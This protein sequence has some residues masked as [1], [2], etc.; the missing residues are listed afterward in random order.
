MQ[1]I[2]SRKI[3]EDKI[4]ENFVD[5]QDLFI[6]IQSNFLTGLHKRYQSIKSGN[7]VL[8]FAKQAH[9]DILKQKDYDFNFNFSFEKFWENHSLIMPTKKSIIKIAKDICIPKETA[10]RK[11]LQLIK[12][13]ILSKKNN[14]TG[15]LPSERYKKSYD[16]FIQEEIDGFTKLL[17][18]ICKKINIS[19]TNEEIKEEIK[20]KFNFYWFHYLNAQ[21]KYLRLWSTQLKDLE[22]TLIGLQVVRIFTSK[23]RKQ[24]ISHENLFNGP[25]I[26]NNFKSTSIS[27]T[28]ISDVTSIPRATCIRKLESL[29]KLK[30]IKQDHISKRYYL[31]PESLSKNVISK[32]VTLEATKTFCEFYFICIRTISAKPSN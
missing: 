17:F 16:L 3:I 29:V 32:E 7:L 30:M 24:N 5:Y 19:I 22:L 2:L 18:F 10:R 21:L 4:L 6:E 13:K 1:P 9:Q 25:S 20:K 14:N 23:I 8:Y 28:S 11:I 27:A 15:W 12:L 31:I 26:M